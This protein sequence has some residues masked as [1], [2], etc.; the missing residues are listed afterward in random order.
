MADAGDNDGAMRTVIN[1]TAVIAIIALLMM[2]VWLCIRCKQAQQYGTSRPKKKGAPAE[3]KKRTHGSVV[4][5][6]AEMDRR[7]GGDEADENFVDL[8]KRRSSSIIG[9][10]LKKPSSEKLSLSRHDS[11]QESSSWEMASAM[12]NNIDVEMQ[13]T[14]QQ[15]QPSDEPPFP[16]VAPTRPSPPEPTPPPA[17]PQQQPPPPP[18]PPLPQH[19]TRAPP[20]I[21]E[22]DEEEEESS[23]E[24]EDYEEEAAPEEDGEKEFWFYVDYHNKLIGPL[25]PNE[26]RKLYLNGVIGHSTRV[27]WH[28]VVDEVPLLEDQDLEDTAELREICGYDMPPFMDAKAE[29]SP[30]LLSSPPKPKQKRPKKKRSVGGSKHTRESV[31]FHD[32]TS[33]LSA[34][35]A[36]AAVPPP[37]DKDHEYW[38][39]VDPRTA[40]LTGP[41]TPASMRTRYQYGAINEQTRIIWRPH[42]DVMPSL[43]E[44]NAEHAAPLIEVCTA[45]GPPFMHARADEAAVFDNTRVK[46]RLNRARGGPQ[47]PPL[48]SAS[49][50]DLAI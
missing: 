23:E 27:S 21:P 39:Y 19:A 10:M 43:D 12:Y 50:S 40:A 9:R 15:K 47:P 42:C 36:S 11:A 3:P 31:Q 35:V 26:M 14:P 28:P 22:A 44:Q 7:F 18:P 29:T 41:L 33:A 24:E 1:I 30:K 34:A 17:K 38:F 46:E 48:Y 13:P 16:E 4:Q 8:E 45:E 32:A 37:A 20:T 25:S 49:S 2:A 6:S 5:P